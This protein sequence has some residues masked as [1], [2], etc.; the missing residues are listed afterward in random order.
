MSRTPPPPP[1]DGVHLAIVTVVR[2]DLSGLLTTRESLLIQ[3]DRNFLW[4]VVDGGSDDGSSA[5]LSD[6]C[7]EI[8]WCRSAPDHGPYD[9]MNVGLAAAQ[10]LGAGHVLF[11]NAG[12]ALAAPGTIGQLRRAAGAAPLAPFLY[13]DSLERLPD[14]SVVGK[15]ARSHR[16]AALGMFTHHQAILYR[17]GAIGDLRFDLKYRIAADYAFTLSALRKAQIGPESLCFPVCLFAPAGLSARESALGR[18]EQRTIRAAILG[19]GLLMNWAISSLQRMSWT[20]RFL[21]PEIYKKVR[22]GNYAT[23]FLSLPINHN[24]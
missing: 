19:T 5:W 6:H 9:A 24:Q 1:T 3:R 14:G 18:A 13:G 11:L 22:F 4:I 15:P 8:A 2:N 10:R 16:M 20:L 23:K 21:S 7:D 12:D 17:C